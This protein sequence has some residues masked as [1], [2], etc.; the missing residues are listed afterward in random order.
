M[1]AT[2]NT[3]RS[4]APPALLVV[5]GLAGACAAA[6]LAIHTRLALPLCV[7]LASVPF[8]VAAGLQL[9]A[10]R[11]A[12]S[13]PAHAPAQ[14]L[15]GRRDVPG[16]GLLLL[17]L[18]VLLHPV[19]FGGEGLVPVS[20][21][22]YFAPW[23]SELGM[24]SM[25]PLLADQYQELLPQ[26][27]FAHERLS[28]GDL[29]LWN[30]HLACGVPFLA[31]MQA[32]ILF[33]VNLIL[34]PLDPFASRGVAALIKLW[35]AGFFTYLYLRRLGGSRGAATL[36][37]IAF[38]FS[39]FMVVWLGHPHTN[40][41]LWLPLLLFL[42]EGE[43]SRH[44]G[45]RWRHWI[46]FALATGALW[47]GGH[48]PTAVHVTAVTGIYFV[49]R[50]VSAR[51][52]GQLA[53]RTLLFASALLC[54]WM[55]AAAQIL[56]FLEYYALSSAP[57]ASEALDRA[58]S[59]LPFIS[60]VYLMIPHLT[61]SPVL[62]FGHMAKYLGLGPEHNFHAYTGFFGVVTLYLATLAVLLRRDR[63]VHFHALLAVGCL[64]VVLGVPPLLAILG[65]L[66]VLGD[67][68]HTRLLLV[69]G[70][71]GAVLGGFGLD[72]IGCRG[73]ERRRLGAKLA[74]W[75]GAAIVLAGAW[76]ALENP[77]RADKAAQFVLRQYAIFA[78]T[79][80]VVGLA[81]LLTSR[82]LL[83][84]GVCVAALSVE[85]LWFAWGYNPSAERSHYYPETAGIE[86]L[87]ADDSVFRVIGFGG[88]LPPDTSMVFGLDDVRGRD[89]MSVR[90]Y[91]EL[92]RGEAG[93]F[94]FLHKIPGLPAATLALNVK[95][96]LTRAGDP[97][98]A[99]MLGT[100]HA[101]EMSIS[102]MQQYVERAIVVRPYQV[103]SADEV[104]EQMRGGAFDPRTVVLLE[105][106]PPGAI[107]GDR[108]AADAD[109]VRITSYAPDRVTLEARLAE[110]GFVVLLDTWFPGWRLHVDGEP[111]PLIRADYN[112]RA[113]RLG[114]G[115][116][117]LA[118][119]YR[120]A[121]F[122]VGATLSLMV[123]FGLAALWF[124]DDPRGKRGTRVAA[125]DS[126]NAPPAA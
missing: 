126:R 27:H 29:P 10:H 21:L 45:R 13:S 59:R 86:K 28:Q 3:T 64:A 87:R 55:L 90:R 109:S 72:G 1:A 6:L 65:G 120:P 24:G 26:Q 71:S 100:V 115:T 119:D 111:A 23:R 40:V 99:R 84:V 101:E 36:S 34:T 43:F 7:L 37:A 33:P 116:W 104:L 4:I 69:V 39:G 30:P 18:V 31:S 63:F 97:S 122:V 16:L 68:A 82:R 48:P 25:N 118:F 106:E 79:L 103:A 114:A 110:P 58:A 95:Y 9:R 53:R 107:A 105:E 8:G 41:A 89:F 74:W 112:F 80:A 83:A 108:P 32:A 17:L 81:S 14:R 93:D 85:M 91:E 47:L 96:V 73:G 56:P 11:R 51:S 62:G 102:Q 35:L 52:E 94:Q 12:L 113:V 50:L 66:P 42:I 124:A 77:V 60:L 98:Y 75:V 44:D 54:G 92:I 38:A 78:V 123:A 20:A 49:F 117:Q 125:T 70:F 88:A 2:V 22:G 57:L 76:S 5:L 121:S 46:G 19:L 67:M 15:L 61:G